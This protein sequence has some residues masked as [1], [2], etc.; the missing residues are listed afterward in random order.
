MLYNSGLILLVVISLFP[1]YEAYP[2]PF[3]YYPMMG[4]GSLMMERPGPPMGPPGPPPGPP[5]PPM[6]PDPMIEPQIGPPPVM[7]P[8]GPQ[9]QIQD[10]LEGEAI[11]GLL[12]AVVGAL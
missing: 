9:N 2:Y 8:F 10:E 11:G 6:G 12:G 5:G 1:T 3:P 4:E 7:G